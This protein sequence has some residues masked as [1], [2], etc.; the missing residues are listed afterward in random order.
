MKENILTDPKSRSRLET[1]SGAF[2]NG[3]EGVDANTLPGD[4]EEWFSDK[5]SDSIG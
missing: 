1:A 3:D 5:Q 2:V 4:S